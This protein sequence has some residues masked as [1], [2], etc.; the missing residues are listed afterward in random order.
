MAHEASDTWQL[1]HLETGHEPPPSGSESGARS[2]SLARPLVQRQVALWTLVRKLSPGH[3]SVRYHPPPRWD[4]N[5]RTAGPADTKW[6]Q[7]TRQRCRSLVLIT[8]TWGL[9]RKAGPETCRGHHCSWG[10][11]S[12]GQCSRWLLHCYHSCCWNGVGQQPMA[13]DNL[14]VAFSHNMENTLYLLFLG[15]ENSLCMHHWCTKIEEKRKP[16]I[17][18][19]W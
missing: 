9:W 10:W 1:N 14:D 8:D 12:P 19:W 15:Q 6:R 2:P 7:T 17:I 4:P 3:P 13:A 18:F 5:S 11:V 16:K